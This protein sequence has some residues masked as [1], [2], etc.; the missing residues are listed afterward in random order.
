MSV[1]ASSAAAHAGIARILSKGGAVRDA[2]AEYDLALGAD[3]D[4]VATLIAG[5]EAHEKVGD[6][7]AAMLLLERALVHVKDRPALWVRLARLYE[8]QGRLEDAVAS[9]WE[10]RAI[11]PANAE[12]GP[13]LKALYEKLAARER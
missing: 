6:L 5:S 9:L 3:S 11:E 7:K 8:S 2:V 12:S 1:E 13:R 4:D 10:A